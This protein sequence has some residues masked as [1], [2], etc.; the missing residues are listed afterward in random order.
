VSQASPHALALGR[1]CF[2]RL[3]DLPYDAA[4]D[5]ALEEFPK[6]FALPP[7]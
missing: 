5:H 6:L 7:E 4:L 1:R 2:Y 3:L